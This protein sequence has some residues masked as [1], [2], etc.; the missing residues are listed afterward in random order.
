METP[1]I[2][3]LGIIPDSF[4]LR[5]K[6]TGEVE[7]VGWREAWGASLVEAMKPLQNQA[8][9]AVTSRETEEGQA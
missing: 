3:G 6:A 9:R 1:N 4:S 7:G 2:R 5:W 8:E